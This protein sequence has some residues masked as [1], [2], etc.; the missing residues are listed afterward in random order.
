LNFEFY[1]PSEKIFCHQGSKAQSYT[2]NK[3]L[4]DKLLVNLGV[5]V[6][7][8]QFY[9][10]RFIGVDSILNF[11]FQLYEPTYFPA[12]FSELILLHPVFGN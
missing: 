12:D 11:E 2:K 7:S 9:F 3:S 5:L 1:V 6:S 4:K 10:F 8:W